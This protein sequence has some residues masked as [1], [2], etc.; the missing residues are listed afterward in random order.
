MNDSNRTI[1][2]R[3]IVFERIGGTGRFEGRHWAYWT[4]EAGRC[5]EIRFVDVRNPQHPNGCRPNAFFT[6]TRNQNTDF[7]TGAG[8]FHVLW[9]GTEIAICEIAAGECDASVPPA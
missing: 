8:D 2:A 3:P 4:M 9:N 6:P 1:N 7:W 5:M